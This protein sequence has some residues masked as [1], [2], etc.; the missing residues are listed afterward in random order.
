MWKWSMASVFA[1][2]KRMFPWWEKSWINVLFSWLLEAFKYPTQKS[3]SILSRLECPLD[4]VGK[5]ADERSALSPAAMPACLDSWSLTSRWVSTL[6]VFL[7]VRKEKTTTAQIAHNLKFS[8]TRQGLPEV[9]LSGSGGVVGPGFSGCFLAW[10]QRWHTQGCQRAGL[11]KGYGA[12]CF[13]LRSLIAV[14]KLWA[15]RARVAT[16]WSI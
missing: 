14:T 15:F 10:F 12:R 1:V 13:R 16:E 5:I 8:K 2:K 3:L 6:G 9:K 7:K 11:M 4:N